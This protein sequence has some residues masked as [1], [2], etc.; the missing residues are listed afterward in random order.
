VFKNL[1]ALFLKS[2]QCNENNAKV[3]HAYAMINYVAIEAE[4]A[5]NWGCVH[6]AAEGFVRSVLCKPQIALEDKNS[7]QNTLRLLNLVFLH[8]HNARVQELF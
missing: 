5:P 2:L 4:H 7:F 1:S 8:G 6:A 3:W